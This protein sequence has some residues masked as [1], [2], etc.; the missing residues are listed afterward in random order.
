MSLSLG[1]SAVGLWV[2]EE[3]NCPSCGKRS[4]FHKV[5]IFLSQHTLA[6]A[7]ASVVA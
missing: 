2:T 5:Y 1:Q 7:A 6:S 3:Q 4:D